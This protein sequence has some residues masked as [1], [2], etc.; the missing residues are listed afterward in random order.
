MIF[1]EPKHISSLFSISFHV[2][3]VLLLLIFK[4][5]DETPEEEYLLVGFG[6]GFGA[7]SPGS[8]GGDLGTTADQKGEPQKVL[9]E[10]DEFK[11]VEAPTTNQNDDERINTKA[12]KNEKDVV[13]NT[14]VKPL[15]NGNSK[16]TG[17]GIGSGEGVGSGNGDG[18]GN[19]GFGFQLDFGGGGKRKIYSYSL[20]EYPEGVSKEIDLKMRFTIMA[21]G[22]VTNIFPVI[23]ADG[24]LEQAAVN[25]LKQWRFE[26]LPSKAK[27]MAQTVVITF[28]YRLQ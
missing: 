11:K 20:P 8:G 27:Q 28:P 5:V 13:G 1:K 3:I 19:G 7:G 2:V 15:F 25:S 23:K 22:T 21:D 4:S 10:K 14:R 9:Q 6:P 18:S 16:G 12:S 26:P 24:R 17:S